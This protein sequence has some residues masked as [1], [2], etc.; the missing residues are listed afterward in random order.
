MSS[1]RGTDALLIVTQHPVGRRRRRC[2][3]WKCDRYT[4]QQL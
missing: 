1:R 3:A 4:T 2:L